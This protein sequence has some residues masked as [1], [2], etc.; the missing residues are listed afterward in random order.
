MVPFQYPR[1][2]AIGE[3][4]GKLGESAGWIEEDQ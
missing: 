4:E 1:A 2:D 3:L